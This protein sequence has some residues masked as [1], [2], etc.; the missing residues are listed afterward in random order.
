MNPI[1]PVVTLTS[2]LETLARVQNRGGVVALVDHGNVCSFND[3]RAAG[4]RVEEILISNPDTLDQAFG[5][6]ETLMRSQAVDVAILSSETIL[7]VLFRKGSSFAMTAQV[8]RAL[9]TVVIPESSTADV[10]CTCGYDTPDG[11]DGDCRSTGC[12]PDCLYCKGPEES[13]DTVPACSIYTGEP[14]GYTCLFHETG[15]LDI[16]PCGRDEYQPPTYDLSRCG[17]CQPKDHDQCGNDAA[18]CSCCAN[19][20]ANLH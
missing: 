6:A 7:A 15:G 8:K 2:C 18:T 13:P 19:T 1:P 9:E 16:N 14:T 12:D 11:P 20:V 10:P 4:I 5:I 3:L 17:P